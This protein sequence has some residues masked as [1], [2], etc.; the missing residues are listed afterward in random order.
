MEQLTRNQAQTKAL[1]VIYIILTYQKANLVVDVGK[2]ISST[3]STPIEDADYFVKA[4]AVGTIK[5]YQEIKDRV[6]PALKDWSWDRINRVAQA[7]FIL[8]IVHKKYID[9]EV[10]NAVI[11][12]IAVKQAKAY[13]DDNDYKYINAVLNEVL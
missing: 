13:L 9:P 11:I 10:D 7:I 4:C 3:L 8:A 5:Y 2:I 6:E 1:E 12:D